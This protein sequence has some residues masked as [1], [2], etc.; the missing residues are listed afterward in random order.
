MRKATIILVMYVRLSARQHRKT[1]FPLYGFSWN[2]I[3]QC[4]YFENLSRKF[5][6][7]L[8]PRHGASSGCGW[9]N[10]LRYGGRLRVYW[11][12][13]RGQPTRGG[14]PYWGLG[15]VL[16][17]TPREKIK[18]LCNIHM[19]AGACEY[20]NELS[21]FHKLRG[22]SWVAA[23]PVSFSRVTVLYGVSK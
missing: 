22:I 13:N 17:T 16:T 4:V 2:L 15:E 9:R 18:I 14:P 6:G 21:G 12:S 1:R 23:K 5:C 7:S 19:V 20:G 3:F 8:S 10:D 11:I